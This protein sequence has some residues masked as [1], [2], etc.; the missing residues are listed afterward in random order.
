MKRKTYPV[1]IFK[2]NGATKT[3]PNVIEEYTL[4]GGEKCFVLDEF[5]PG[6]GLRIEKYPMAVIDHTSTEHRPHVGTSK[7]TK[8]AAKPRRG[9]DNA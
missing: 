5:G 3:Y 9:A 6:G 4:E 8:D 1:T 2:R 7:P